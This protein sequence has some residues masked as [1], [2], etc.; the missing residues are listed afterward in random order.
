MQYFAQDEAA[1]LDPTQTVYSDA[2]RRLADPD[3]PAHP[4]DPRRLPV[5][6]RRHRE[7]GAGAVRRRA[8]AAGRRAHAAPPGQH[9]AARRAD[10]PSRSRLEGRAAR[11]ARGLR[12]HPDLRLAR[13]L[14]RRQAGDQDHRDRPRRRVGVSGQ[15]RR[16]PVEQ[17]A[18]RGRGRGSDRR[19]PRSGLR[20]ATT[21]RSRSANGRQRGQAPA[22]P[23]TRDLGHR[24]DRTR[25]RSP[26]VLRRQ[27]EGGRGSAGA[28]RKE[29]EARQ[30]RI[31]GAR[32]ADR[33][34]RGGIKE[35]EAADV[36]P[37]VSTKTTRTPSPSSTATRP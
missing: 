30:R 25:R 13:S 35:L 10:Q 14:L 31:A 7:A 3:G 2:G 11:R 34:G 28:S 36:G 4:D 15:L 23:Q 19:R 18:A 29:A 21:P 37:R 16:V 9:A 20:T 17:E 24:P 32:G 1:K 12:R 26:A 22:K 6:G 5:L 8:H 27:E 33:Q